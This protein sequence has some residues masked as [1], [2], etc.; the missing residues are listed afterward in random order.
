M[1]TYY[2]YENNYR[3]ERIVTPHTLKIVLSTEE[4]VE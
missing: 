4:I 1:E 3:K 2:E